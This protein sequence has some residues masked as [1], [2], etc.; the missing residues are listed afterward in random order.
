LVNTLPETRRS[1]SQTLRGHDITPEP[2]DSVLSE[3]QLVTEREPLQ[4]ISPEDMKY[5]QDSQ[6]KTYI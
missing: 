1:P 5:M 4:L 3:S 6:K 2:E